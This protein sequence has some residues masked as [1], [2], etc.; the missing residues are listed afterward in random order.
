MAKRKAVA[1]RDVVMRTACVAFVGGAGISGC[2]APAAP[3]TAF[4][5]TTVRCGGAAAPVTNIGE[6]VSS[7]LPETLPNGTIVNGHAISVECSVSGSG[8]ITLFA[9]DNAEGTSTM[10][11]S[12]TY[13]SGSTAG[14]SSI[15]GTFVTAVTGQVYNG[16]NCVLTYTF[17]GSS[18]LPNNAVGLSAG[19]IWGHVSCPEAEDQGMASE[20]GGSGS[21]T[22]DVESDFLFENCTE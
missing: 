9:N 8:S 12:A 14:G 4:V 2:S 17:N 16:T 3:A 18:S 20:D 1:I 5:N 7:A 21:A 15:D 13:T 19:L 22:C 11:G 6:I 10:T